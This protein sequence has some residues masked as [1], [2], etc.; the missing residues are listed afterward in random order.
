MLNRFAHRIKGQL[1]QLVR[2]SSLPTNPKP[3]PTQNYWLVLGLCDPA[4]N[5]CTIPV[6]PP[7]TVALPSSYPRL[8]ALLYI[9]IYIPLPTTLCILSSNSVSFQTHHHHLWRRH[10]WKRRGHAPSAG[11]TATTPGHVP[12]ITA[13]QPPDSCFSEWGW[14]RRRVLQLILRRRRRRL[15]S[16]RAW[17]W[18]ICRCTSS[19]RKIPPATP[20]RMAVTHPTT[21]FMLPVVGEVSAREVRSLIPN[22]N[23]DILFTFCLASDVELLLK[24]QMIEEFVNWHQSKSKSMY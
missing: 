2:L 14:R 23:F 1:P 13:E 21:P 20:R 8:P 17:V 18:I 5:A 9:T 6:H 12:P 3:N 16:G 22:S 11:T 4:R 24:G 15:L 10:L 19:S 7:I